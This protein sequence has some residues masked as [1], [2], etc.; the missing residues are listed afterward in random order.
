M[1][2]H[3]SIKDLERESLTL[4]VESHIDSYQREVDLIQRLITLNREKSTGLSG[5]PK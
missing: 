4:M 3:E 5:I 2:L 1:T